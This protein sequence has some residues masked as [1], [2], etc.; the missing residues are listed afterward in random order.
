ML[1]RTERVPRD[2]ERREDYANLVEACDRFSRPNLLLFLA[3]AG[4]QFDGSL[5]WAG[6]TSCT[7]RV[8]QHNGQKKQHRPD[9][10]IAEA[11][12]VMLPH[13]S[14][15]PSLLSSCVHCSVWAWAQARNFAGRQ[16]MHRYEL[17]DAAGT[18]HVAKKMLAARHCARATA[19]QRQ[20]SGHQRAEP[21]PFRFRSPLQS[22]GH[23]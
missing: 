23:L 16:R 22:K 6:L 2:Q 7:L 9:R 18:Y 21:G 10:T 12:S 13:E 11:R 3:L 1:R 20:C 4:R 19:T 17:E 8:L 5:R 15:S 14:F